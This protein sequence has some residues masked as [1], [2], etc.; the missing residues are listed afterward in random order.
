[1]QT[2]KVFLIVGGLLTTKK[3]TS[4]TKNIT[5]LKT[6]RTKPQLAV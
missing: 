4:Q 1:L 2:G 5:K 3:T 6:S